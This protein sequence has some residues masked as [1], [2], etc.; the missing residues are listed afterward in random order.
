MRRFGSHP[1]TLGALG[2]VV[3]VAM[4]TGLSAVSSSGDPGTTYGYL[5]LFNEVLALVRHNYVEDVPD[6]VLLKGAYE[7]LLEALDGESEYLSAIQYQQS[8]ADPTPTPASA[9]M[10]LTRRAGFLFV[11]AVLQ[12]S[13]AE[14][15]GVRPGDRIRRIAN[16]PAASIAYSEA[17]RLLRGNPGAK[18][19][20]EISRPEE[21]DRIDIQVELR[22]N[23]LPLP[24]LA[25]MAGTVA[26]IRL[27]AFGPGAGATFSGILDKLHRNGTTRMVVDLR[28]NAW[29]SP[30]EAIRAAS[31]LTGDGVQAVIRGRGTADEPVRGEGPRTPWRGQIL[32]LT[33]P[34]TAL[35]AELFVAT[36]ADAGLATHA[37]ESTL[38]R[39]GEREALP[40][41]DG[42]YLV[43]TVRKYVSPRGTTWH[44][45]G[46]KPSVSI[47]VDP[48]L[49]FEK[50]A[51]RQLEKA[52]EWLA[53]AASEAKAA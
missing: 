35:A 37:G 14:A 46:L 10:V 22:E 21:P 24:T 13:G 44:G 12:G 25:A 3:T 29:G 38:G 45:E 43:L 30:E 47:P 11:A 26:V 31:L 4:A 2:L 17:Q 9:G 48:D 18:V 39:A 23:P 41:A 5:K 49:P 52:K 34:G 40:L 15:G 16:R 19:T 7:G 33:N 50:R 42:G 8:V 51:D 36:L 28:D 1:V 6:S 32:L 27:P 53:A 20:L